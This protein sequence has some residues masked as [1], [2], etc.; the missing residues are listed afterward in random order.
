MYFIAQDADRLVWR[1]KGFVA[2][3][4][5]E[6]VPTIEPI[7]DAL[8]DDASLDSSRD[9]VAEVLGLVSLPPLK[10]TS[11]RCVGPSFEPSFSFPPGRPDPVRHENL[12]IEFY[13]GFT[14]DARLFRLPSS[15]VDFEISL[16]RIVGSELTCIVTLGVDDDQEH[17]PDWMESLESKLRRY[18][19]QINIENE[20]LTQELKN[21]IER[22]VDDRMRRERAR[23]S[24]ASRIPFPISKYKDVP[25]ALQVPMGRR[26]VLQSV[27]TGSIALERTFVDEG[28]FDAIMDLIATLATAVERSPSV[29]TQLHE[30]Q[31]RDLLLVILNSHFKGKASGETFNLRG[32]ADILI[33]DNDE[34]LLV[35]ECK[36]WKGTKGF[37]DGLDQLLGRYVVWSDLRLAIIIFNEKTNPSAILQSIEN[38]MAKREEAV[39]L[40]RRGLRELRFELPNPRDVAT[41]CL[42]AI[43]VIDIPELDPTS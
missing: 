9:L 8:G 20:A 21:H 27:A 14:G 7:L 24:L 18:V 17:V 34:N 10:I 16:W 6:L 5:R 3:L 30:P 1:Q 11:V 13:A 33:R 42:L 32:K 19:D 37:N 35:A 38:A 23:R 2:G 31:L 15:S 25:D 36:K 12:R 4:G 29:F 40:G 22:Q 28:S 26:D 43:S 39:S 41:K